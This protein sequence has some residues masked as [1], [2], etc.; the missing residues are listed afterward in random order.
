[1]TQPYVTGAV[2]IFVG[3]MDVQSKATNAQGGGGGSPRYLGTCEAYPTFAIRPA[4]FP[5]F[6][7]I[8]GPVIPY[9]MAF[10]G[11]EAFTSANLT[12]WDEEVYK[13]IASRPTH[14]GIGSGTPD[15]GFNGYFDMGTLM[16][17]EG[18]AFALYL[19]F[20]YSVIQAYRGM[21][22]GYKFHASWAVGPDDHNRQGT[23][24]KRL[25]L[26]FHSLRVPTQKGLRLY[27]NITA[28]DPVFTAPRF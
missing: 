12:L 26:L 3:P 2:H 10:V 21:P 16:I 13:S 1:M 9:D 27:S 19:L 5:L 6:N 11:E 20:P 18:M 28:N 24:P 25:H 22:A 23:T 4:F 7:D 8:T 14:G 15:R 17:H